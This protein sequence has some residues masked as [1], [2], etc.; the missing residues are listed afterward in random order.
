M[1]E[2]GNDRPLDCVLQSKESE[3]EAMD[4]ESVLGMELSLCTQIL[5]AAT[6]G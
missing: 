3:L 5:V 2:N 6:L 4:Q 1:E